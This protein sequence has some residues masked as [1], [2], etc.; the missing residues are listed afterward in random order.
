MFNNGNDRPQGDYSTVEEIATTVDGSGDYP[1]PLP[2]LPHGPA[3]AEWTFTATPPE[4]LWSFFISGAHRLPNGNTLICEGA[5]GTLLEV[6]S[7]D[8]VV[9]IYVSPVNANGPQHQGDPPGNN[10]VFRTHRYAPDYAGF[11]GRDLTPGGPIEIYTASGVGDHLASAQFTLFPNYPN[12]FR[13]QTTFRFSL[14]RP[15][16][17]V[18]DVHDVA[19]RHVARLVDERLGSGDHR[20][21]WDASGLASGVYLYSLRVGVDRA[22]GKM[23]L[24]R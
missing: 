22:T 24:A 15:D 3:N 18:L 20:L 1:V 13:P 2:G 10:F 6:D 9:W 14:T 7:L 4:S 5:T 8:Q 21:A 23:T 12:P 16:L 19:G 17:V 11:D